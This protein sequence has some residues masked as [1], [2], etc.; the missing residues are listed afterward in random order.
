M[1][2]NE[3]IYNYIQENS[4]KYTK[5]QLKGQV[6]FD[7]QEIAAELDIL[8]NNVSKELNELHRQDKII[9][10]TGRPVRYFDKAA[11]EKLLAID[12]GSGPCQYRDVEQCFEL[13]DSSHEE[14]NPFERLI[15]AD[16]SLKRQVE[17]AKAAILYPPDGLHTLIV[18]QTGVA[19][20]CLPT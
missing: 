2:R 18:G 12:L 20:P 13:N 7:A 6:G 16:R 19:R 9:K 8:R 4:A 17:Q 11:L 15:G 3:R 14:A 10:F 1:K 5:E